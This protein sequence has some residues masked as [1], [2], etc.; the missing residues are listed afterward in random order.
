M[1][2]KLGPLL[3]QLPPSL[4]FEPMVIE[5]FFAFL[6]KS[7]DGGIVCEPRHTSWFDECAEKMLS[8]FQVGRVAADPAVVP[9]AS[10][11]GGWRGIEYFRLH[12]SPEMYYSAYL[13]EYLDSLTERLRAAS[14]TSET[15][16]IFDNTARGHA[17]KNALDVIER[18]KA[19]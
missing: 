8:D 3:V 10:Q 5:N 1:C 6:R 16:C 17:S 9:Q 4:T 18:L 15:W 11:P 14:Q 19:Y 7:F 2:D 12:G 13:D